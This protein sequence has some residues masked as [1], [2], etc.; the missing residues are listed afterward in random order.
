MLRVICRYVEV[1]HVNDQ[2]WRS[3]VASADE[4]FGL[5]RNNFRVWLLWPGRT[6]YKANGR[7][8]WDGIGDY[9][10]PSMGR[11][12]SAFS[13]CTGLRRKM[14]QMRVISDATVV[15]QSLCRLVRWFLV[16]LSKWR[17]VV[18]YRS[19]ARRAKRDGRLRGKHSNYLCSSYLICQDS[20]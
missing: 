17:E 20:W 13:R 4:S 15:L 2:T 16:V 1:R 14:R 8:R 5:A 6:V 18:S 3:I 9:E 12:L 19:T 11:Y 10:G 7:L